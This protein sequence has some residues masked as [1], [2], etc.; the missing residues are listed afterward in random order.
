MLTNCRYSENYWCKYEPAIHSVMYGGKCFNWCRS[1]AISLQSNLCE[2]NI[3]IFLVHCGLV[4]V[5]LIKLLTILI[6]L[7]VASF[8]TTNNW[9]GLRQLPKHNMDIAGANSLNM[10]P[11]WG[12]GYPFQGMD[13]HLCI[14]CFLI[15]FMRHLIWY[16]CIAETFLHSWPVVLQSS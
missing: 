8:L 10:R 15:Y 12:G 14:S 3:T 1:R 6:C 16:C 13:F 7:L 4:I 5:F 2:L 9:T 11:L